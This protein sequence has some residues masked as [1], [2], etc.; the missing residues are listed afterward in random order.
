[1]SNPNF[2]NGKD[3]QPLLGYFLTVLSSLSTAGVVVLGKW[4][5]TA[6]DPLLRGGL[7]VFIAGLMLLI[8]TLF[9]TGMAGFKNMSAIAWRYTALYSLVSIAALAAFWYG[10]SLVE[11]DKV[12]FLGRLQI[13]V[14]FILAV[15]FL[16]EQFHKLEM[17]AAAVVFSG[18][19]VLYNTFPS[20][21]SLGFW[22]MLISSFS[23]GVVEIL[24]KITVSHCEPYL[25]N[26]VR[27][28]AAGLVLIIWAIIR[29]TT[30]FDMGWDWFR[31]IC[32]AFLGP[33]CGRVF[34]LYA[35]KYTEVT[36][37]SLVSQVQP[38]F[39]VILAMIF[40]REYPTSK[41]LLG[42][43]LI[44]TGCALVIVFHPAASRRIFRPHK[45][46]H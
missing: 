30:D 18:M 19:V 35:L 10:L 32:M 29:G 38:I 12:G 41:E 34:Y 6:G 2:D 23:S 43:A 14:I 40:L 20:Q 42:G 28:I 44:V 22:I 31:I 37:T 8:G 26:T 7:V 33:V 3:S 1:M 13:V 11:V 17:A 5:M 24:A 4:V 39:I 15:V 27:N 45:Y 16:K 46:F 21:M 25:F 9:K 36:K